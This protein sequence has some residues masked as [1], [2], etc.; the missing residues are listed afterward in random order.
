MAEWPRSSR[1]GGPSALAGPLH[2][3][4][5]ESPCDAAGTFTCPSC[6]SPASFLPGTPSTQGHVVQGQEGPSLSYGSDMGPREGEL[7]TRAM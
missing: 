7:S 5:Q 2:A 6:P 4:V 3:L 1:V